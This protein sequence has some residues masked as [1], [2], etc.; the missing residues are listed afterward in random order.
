[1]PRLILRL[2]GKALRQ[3]RR[4]GDDDPWWHSAT[5]QPISNLAPQHLIGRIGLSVADPASVERGEEE[6]LLLAPHQGDQVTLQVARTLLIVT[7]EEEGRHLRQPIRQLGKEECRCRAGK[8]GEEEPSGTLPL[9][10]EGADY[11][12]Q[13]GM[14]S[15][16]APQ[17]TQVDS[18]GCR[19]FRIFVLHLRGKG[20]A[21]PSPRVD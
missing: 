13:S 1:M 19:F 20:T 18:L 21:F 9:L 7:D 8:T 16:E 14:L 15:V 10:G 3:R 2:V 12:L 4:I 5:P 6:D 11:R 17:R